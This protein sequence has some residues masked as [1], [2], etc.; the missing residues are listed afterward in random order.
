MT[1]LIFAFGFAL[2]GITGIFA[3]GLMQAVSRRD[4]EEE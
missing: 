3:M 2:G 1:I 4:R